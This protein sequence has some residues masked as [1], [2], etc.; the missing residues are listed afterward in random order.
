MRKNY[1]R[2]TNI[3]YFFVYSRASIRL[4]NCN[5]NASFK[6]IQVIQNEN[7]QEL[8][9]SNLFFRLSTPKYTD[10]SVSEVEKTEA[11][12][13]FIP[14]TSACLTNSR[15]AVSIFNYILCG[16][17]YTYH[18][19]RNLHWCTECPLFSNQNMKLNV[20]QS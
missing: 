17:I 20:M 7:K 8:F 3:H 15:Y 2:A 18:L 12:R 6:T 1:Q 19:R 14:F 11:A 16:K 5:Y 13:I 10:K 4:H 9:S